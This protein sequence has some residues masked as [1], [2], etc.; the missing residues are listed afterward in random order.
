MKRQHIPRSI[1]DYIKRH[2]RDD[3]LCD[4]TRYRDAGGRI[5]YRVE[6]SKDDVM[7]R[8]RFNEKGHIIRQT[9]KETFPEDDLIYR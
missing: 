3:F 1:S 4:V 5:C 9:E 6:I 8:L 2:F 7:H